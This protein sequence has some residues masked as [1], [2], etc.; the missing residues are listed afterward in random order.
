MYSY[1]DMEEGRLNVLA[2]WHFRRY[3]LPWPEVLTP[4]ASFDTSGAT[5]SFWTQICMFHI[6]GP[7]VRGPNFARSE[8][9]RLP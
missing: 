7:P 8:D 1:R 9:V 6:H 5:F 3:D 2:R 4:Q